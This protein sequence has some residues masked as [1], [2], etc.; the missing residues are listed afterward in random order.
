[1]H[2]LAAVPVCHFITMHPVKPCAMGIGSIRVL[3]TERRGITTGVPFLATCRA[4]LAANAG[5]QVDDQSKFLAAAFGDLCH[6]VF[7]AVNSE[8]NVST[9][10][11]SGMVL[12]AFNSSKRG[13]V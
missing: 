2:R 13:D 11:A 3:I 5:V 9:S 12:G 1:M 6:Q 7:F 4:G 8:P 10:G